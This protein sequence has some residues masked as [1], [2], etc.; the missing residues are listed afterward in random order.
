[1]RKSSGS[2]MRVVSNRPRE[3]MA[4][5]LPTDI[6][7]QKIR[8]VALQD[9]K[10]E[11][12]WERFVRLVEDA[13]HALH[14]ESVHGS[15]MPPGPSIRVEDLTAALWRLG[16]LPSQ[17][18]PDAT[19]ESIGADAVVLARHLLGARVWLPSGGYGP[20]PLPKW[21]REESEKA[22]EADEVAE[23]PAVQLVEMK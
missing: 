22:D 18:V 2:R 13:M 11:A 21:L 7:E 12:R 8:S 9:S 5:Q 20:E 3:P 4:N 15:K 16:E 6:A 1:M 14:R 19:P 23:E 17:V 10:V